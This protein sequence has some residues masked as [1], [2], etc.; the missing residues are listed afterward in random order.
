MK[1]NSFFLLSILLISACAETDT[2]AESGL[3]EEDKRPNLL[4]IVADDLGYADIELFGGEIETPELNALAERGLMLTR[5]Y[6]SS[7]CSPTRAMLMTGVDTH[8]N[9]LGNMAETTASNQ[10]GVPGYEGYLNDSV[11]T[12]PELLRDAGYHTYM[13]GKW[14]LGLEPAHGPGVRGFERSFALL[15]GGAGHF[16]MS[17]PDIHRQKALY[18]DDGEL[19]ESLPEDFYSTRFYTDKMIEYIESDRPDGKPFFGFLGYTAPHWPL[20]APDEYLEKQ[21]GRYDAGYDEIRRQRFE[22]MKSKGVI[23]ATATYPSR[24]GRIPAWQDLSEAEQ[25]ASA[26]SMEAYAA[27]VE[28]LDDNISRFLAYLESVGELENTFIVFLSDNGADGFSPDVT[29]EIFEYAQQFDNRLENIGRRNSFV[30][31]GPSW[32]TTGSAA[33]RMFKSTAAEGGYRVPAIVVPPGGLPSARRSGQIVTA[34]DVLPTFLE[35]AETSHPGATYRGR[36]V[37]QPIGSS[38]VDFVRGDSA[39]VHPD[40][41]VFGLEIW[42]RISVTQGDWKLVKQPPPFGQGEWELYDLGQ[43]LG[44]TQNLADMNKQKLSEMITAWESYRDQ[45][46]VI[47]ANEFRLLPA[48][49]PDA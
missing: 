29:P 33:L 25:A 27:M 49:I 46:N 2:P 18:R 8:L 14:H 7:T 6:T 10:V 36:E 42:G 21:R 30:I 12:L 45:N 41:Y 13:A 24:I 35:L 43:D 47:P 17:G 37:H 39:G 20:Q 32:A 9:G 40:D 22:R 23:P 44:E 48:T 19:V 1:I 3:V 16:D 31:Y 11:A 4:L 5:F 34:L 28:N 26:R 15:W 38:I